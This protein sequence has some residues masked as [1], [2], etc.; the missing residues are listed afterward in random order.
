MQQSELSRRID[1]LVR[2]FSTYLRTFHEQNPFSG[3][4]LRGHTRTIEFRRQLGTIGC[5]AGNEAFLRSLYSTLEAFGMNQ[6]AAQLVSLER[7]SGA[8]RARLAGFAA[9]EGK[10]L[11]GLGTEVQEITDVLW[12][13]ID[14][15]GITRTKSRLVA[16]TKALHHLLPRLVPPMDRAYTAAFFGWSPQ[17]VQGNEEAFFRRAF[18]A[19]GEVAR[20]VQPEQYV[21]GGWNSSITK[22]VDNSVVGYC[23]YHLLDQASRQKAAIA[24]AKKTGIYEQIVAHAE[25]H[26][27]DNVARKATGQGPSAPASSER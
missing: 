6:R 18:P 8:F 5:A 16:G 4:A 19:L 10:R 26:T 14:T 20:R 25:A 9:L 17:R 1:D 12:N 21:S 22:V 13:V 3:D 15:L 2:E 27:Q 11:D 23:K 24:W 7:F